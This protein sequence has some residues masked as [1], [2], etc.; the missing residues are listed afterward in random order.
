MKKEKK[1]KKRTTHTLILSD[2]HLGSRVSRSKKAIELLESYKFE[3]L[4]L[5]GDIF[6]NLDFN[7]LRNSEWRLLSLIS[8]FS[9]KKK[10]RWIEGNHDKGLTKIFAAFTGAKAYKTYK[11]SYNGKKYLAIHGH[12]F[13]N[14]LIDN[15]LLSYLANWIYNLVQLID[16]PDKRM[17][18][19]IKRKSKGWLRLSEKVAKRAL[20]Y[21]KLMN[22]DYIFCGH[23]HRALHRKKKD[24]HYYNSGCWT[25]SPCSFIVLDGDKIEIK[26]Y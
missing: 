26:K 3:K 13:D 12:Q 14:F 1:I 6:E 8:A 11:W 22:V 7:R 10:V 16:F 4:I 18:R 17:S 24:I 5:L 19:Y 25:D 21:A 9:R 15:A 2:F 20:L 23:T